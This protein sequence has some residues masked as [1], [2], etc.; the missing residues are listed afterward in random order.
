VNR[1]VAQNIKEIYTAYKKRGW[2]YQQYIA[3]LEPLKEEHGKEEYAL[4]PQMYGEFLTN[5]FELWYKELQNGEQPYI[6]Q[7]ENYIAVMLGYKAEAC[8]HNGI[9]GVQYVTE[10]DGSVYPCDFYMLDE[11]KLGN[12][13]EDKIDTMNEKRKEIGFI[14]NSMKLSDKCKQCKYYRLCK[15]G[16]QRNRDF[17]PQDGTYENYLCGGFQYFFDHCFNKMV[18][19]INDRDLW[20]IRN[21]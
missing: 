8:D 5:L 20:K 15:G 1:K 4:T 6:R 3:C 13:N 9:C 12:F 21:G 16:C 7:F 18:T 2:K 11:Y 14:E 17:I 19:I 10:A